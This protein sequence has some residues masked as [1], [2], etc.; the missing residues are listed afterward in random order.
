MRVA[1]LSVL[2]VLFVA[3]CGGKSPPPAECA[4]TPRVVEPSE[5]KPFSDCTD[6]DCRA[7]VRAQF[8]GA[9]VQVTALFDEA[10]KEGDD[11]IT[12][13]GKLH[14]AMCAC[15]DEACAENVSKD[16]QGW[17]EN[18]QDTKGTPEQADKAG[19]LVGDM[20]K[21]YDAATGGG[22]EGDDDDDEDD[23]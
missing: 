22:D 6:D 5:L 15:K 11:A 1:V 16:F 7:K 23:E 12:E 17:M 21:C 13:L 8:E 18:H 19:K 10:A 9:Y 14:D 3:A 2:S 20:Q 4:A